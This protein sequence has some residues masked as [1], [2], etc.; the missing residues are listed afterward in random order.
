MAD[1]ITHVHRDGTAADTT[2]MSAFMIIVLFVALL[3]LGAFVFYAVNGGTA[4]PADNATPTDNNLDIG[5]N[6]QMDVPVPG[7]NNPATPAQ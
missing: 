2:G 6:G 1:N 5:V 7:N 3:A 4:I